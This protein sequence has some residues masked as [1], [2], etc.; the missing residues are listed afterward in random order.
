[1]LPKLFVFKRKTKKKEKI[2]AGQNRSDD[3]SD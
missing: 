2:Q 1:M 3:H